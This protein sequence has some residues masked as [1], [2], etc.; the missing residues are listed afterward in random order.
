MPFFTNPRLASYF[1]PGYP[2]A[3][4]AAMTA[5]N[6]AVSAGSPSGYFVSSP[7]L[8]Q[9]SNINV[10]L[11]SS[12]S[13]Y[14]PG[15]S[16]SSLWNKY[17]P[18]TWSTANTVIGSVTKGGSSSS[19]L[20]SGYAS[21]DGS[22]TANSSTNCSLAFPFPGSTNWFQ[23]AMSPG[24]FNLSYLQY[25]NNQ[26]YSSPYA[27]PNLTSNMTS[28]IGNTYNL[29]KTSENSSHLMD[30]RSS[31]GSSMSPFN[32]FNSYHDWNKDSFSLVS[33]LIL[34]NKTMK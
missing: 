19:T 28:P 25:Q 14:L 27:Y 4:A 13:A 26:P 31:F 3:I 23:S 15:A 9:K 2:A 1:L 11:P 10:N 16:G 18:S 29:S 7:P 22:A 20:S 12:I 17:S 21:S 24:N 32:F 8:T 5:M 6:A 30:I 33:N 34:N